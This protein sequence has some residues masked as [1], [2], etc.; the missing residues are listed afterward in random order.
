MTD[1]VRAVQHLAERAPDHLEEVLSGPVS[2]LRGHPVWD[3]ASLTSTTTTGG[4]LLPDDPASRTFAT[5]VSA[6]V[7]DLSTTINLRRADEMLPGTTTT[8]SGSRVAIARPA[9]PWWDT[10]EDFLLCASYPPEG[11]RDYTDPDTPP[12]PDGHTRLLVAAPDRGGAGVALVRA[13]VTCRNP[14]GLD[15]AH[16]GRVQS[17]CTLCAPRL[18]SRL[19]TLAGRLRE[20]ADPPP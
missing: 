12:R 19:L 20:W 9:M 13:V 17:C 4:G 6:T 14:T 11:A 15:L 10:P 1:V 8:P 18:Q 3:L 5:E 2:V 7:R 16:D